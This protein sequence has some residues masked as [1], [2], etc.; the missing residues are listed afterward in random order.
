M[1]GMPTYLA[2]YLIVASGVVVFAFVKFE[3]SWLD[4]TRWV[5][6]SLILTTHILIDTNILLNNQ[7]RN[8]GQI[9]T[10]PQLPYG[11]EEMDEAIADEIKA[12]KHIQILPTHFGLN[13]FSFMHRNPLAHYFGPYEALPPEFA[14]Q[15]LQLYS[16]PRSDTW[17]YMPL[18][19]PEKATTG[20][21]YLG[22]N[23][24]WGLESIFGY[25]ND[26]AARHPDRNGYLLFQIVPQENGHTILTPFKAGFSFD[27]QLQFRFSLI[28]KH[29]IYAQRDW[30]PDPT[31]PIE[32]ISTDKR[33]TRLRIEVRHNNET[34]SVAQYEKFI[35][36]P[37]SWRSQINNGTLKL[38]D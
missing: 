19:I 1:E 3:K 35:G 9:F 21:T 14:D 4:T 24:A 33:P 25:G 11:W 36:D 12:A 34:G 32:P 20:L 29:Q 5:V 37:G 27:D 2:H 18:Y 17:N 22:A 15:T 23:R 38:S 8:L 30:S 7:F 6:I 31:W 28:N 16:A 10:S 13:Y 26:I